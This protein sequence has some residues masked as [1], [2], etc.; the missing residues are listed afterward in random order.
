MR[1]NAL[2]LIFCIILS[3][4]CTISIDIDISCVQRQSDHNGLISSVSCE[5]GETMVS[6]GYSSGTPANTFIG[7]N[8][9]VCYAESLSGGCQAIGRCCTF[10]T[11]AQITTSTIESTATGSESASVQ[12]DEGTVLTGCSYKMVSG[13][14]EAILG[15][16][17]G[18]QSSPPQTSA[19]I[20]TG[21]QC[22]AE[23]PSGTLVQAIA[24][25][26][27]IA[28]TDYTLTCETKAAYTNYA[29]FGTCQSG[30]TMM[31]C[32]AWSSDR[33]IDG[34]FVDT[35]DRCYIQRNGHGLH[36][37][38]AIC[39]S[40]TWEEKCDEPAT[41]VWEELITS[42]TDKPSVTHELEIDATS[43]TLSIH[44]EADYLGK[45]TADNNGEVYGTTY[46]IDFEDFNAHSDDIR[47]PG[48]CQ[49]RDG[50]DFEDPTWD[51]VWAFSET[52]NAGHVGGVDY[53]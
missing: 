2:E 21:N 3:I 44:V 46:V 16:F 43:L 7:N 4:V 25:C 27:S 12:C 32:A 24:R 29:N 41:F 17:S 36:Y 31:A 40:M 38:N 34:Q 39:C 18:V 15:A 52:P 8:N 48:T 30:L 14:G 1:Y 45:T 6:C 23:S 26:A 19:W 13:S 33:G 5:A 49:N 28:N 35:N 42:A 10:P 53:L 9:N 50:D 47:E 11:N 22:N 20:S 51:E 37:G